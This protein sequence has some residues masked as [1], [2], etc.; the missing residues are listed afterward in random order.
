MAGYA[1]QPPLLLTN[2][3]GVATLEASDRFTGTTQTG[4][5]IGS[6]RVRVADLRG[7]VQQQLQK[8]AAVGQEI[9]N[10]TGLR[11]IVTAGASPQPVTIALA[12][13]AFGR[14]ALHLSEQWTAVMV[15]LVVLQQ[16]DRESLALFALI[17]VVCGI[18]L[19][20]ASL[21]GV[22]GP[23]RGDCR[24][25]PAAWPRQ[26]SPSSSERCA[27]HR[28]HRCAVLWCCSIDGSSMAL[29]MW[30]AALVCRS[31]RCW[32]SSPGSCRRGWPH[33]S[34]PTAKLSPR[35]RGLHDSRPAARSAPSP[36]SHSPIA[37]VP[38]ARSLHARRRRPRRRYGCTRCAAGGAGLL[39][40][41]D[42]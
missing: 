3:A 10:A 28:R 18:F 6:I 22:R 33:V 12:A 24:R 4:A 32:P 29:P 1:Q 25:R 37:R 8:I 36:A 21:A 40:L 13:T 38:H 34:E 23:E 30:R 9:R 11:V 17:L 39:R 31:Q 41:G 7:S 27:R 2:L 35:R 26:C 16:A 19:A 15:A 42:R 20:E 5:P 14:P